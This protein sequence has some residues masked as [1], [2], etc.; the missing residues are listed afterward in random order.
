MNIKVL[1]FGWEF[2]PHHTG[3][4]GAACYGLTRSLAKAN[5]KVT[6]V[7]P[8]AL[9][10]VEHDF[11]KMVFADYGIKHVKMRPINVALLPYTTHETYAEYLER[12]KTSISSFGL[13]LIDEVRRYSLLAEQVA[14]DE[15]YDVIHAHDWLSFGAGI[16]AKEVSGKPLI[17]HVH[18]TEFDR[19]GGHPNQYIYD[20]E[21]RGMHAA[22]WVVAVSHRTKQ[23]IVEHYAIDPNKVIVMHNGLDHEEHQRDL[24]QILTQIRAQGKKIVLFLGRIT[25]QKGPDH[26]LNVAKR[27]LELDPNVIFVITG[28]GDMENRIIRMSAELGISNNIIFT[29]SVWG[30]QRIQLYRAADM[31]VMPSVSEPFG[32]TALEALA[33]GTPLLISKQTGAGEVVTHSLRSDFWDIDDMADK[34]YNTLH[35]QALSAT[36]RE[37]GLLDVKRMTWD[38]VADKCANLYKQAIENS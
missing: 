16:A 22:D 8:R 33:N 25:I 9:P 19:T 34:I 13:T 5:V 38:T 10:G 3:G 18:A 20:E 4:L 27:V 12:I 37:F 17:V 30:D 31:Y 1:M 7:L 32:I 11:L 6:F 2:P 36:L 28:T 24:P 35:S 23:A 21:R 29:G 14:M 15:E 26:F